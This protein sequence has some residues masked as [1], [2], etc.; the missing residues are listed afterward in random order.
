MKKILLIAIAL[1]VTTLSYS[2]NSFVNNFITYNVTTTNTNNPTVE[3]TG[4][5]VAGGTSVVIPPTVTNNSTTYAITGIASNSFNNKNL[6]SV[7]IPNG[8][9]SIGSHAFTINSLT[10]IVIPNTVTNIGIS[11]FSFNQITSVIIPNSVTILGTIAFLNNQLTSLTISENITSI[12]VGVFQGNQLTSVVIPD[13]VTVINTNAFFNN[14]LTDIT[15]P[16]NVVIVGARAFYGNPLNSVTSL[17]TSAPS[18]TKDLVNDSFASNRSTIDLYIPI[19][20]TSAYNVFAWTGFAST[21]EGTLSISNFEIENN[22]KLL[23]FDDKIE[24][25]YSNFIR[26]NNYRLYTISGKQVQ[27]GTENSIVKN[28]LSSGI[29]I[30]KLDFD[31]VTLT[32]KILIN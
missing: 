26:L 14:Q 31:K 17:K 2:Q 22:I 9:T 30:L 19:G 5:N 1:F 13:G 23:S 11:A 25:E 28:H 6:T 8:V 16:A 7:T 18:A 27:F 21:T 4:Y 20:S 32:K 29:Y 3:T 24:I 15:I 10:S 12:E